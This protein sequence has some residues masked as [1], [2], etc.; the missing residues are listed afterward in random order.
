MRARPASWLLA[1]V[2]LL[3]AVLATG[4]L[5]ACGAVDNAQHVVDRSSL[6]NDLANRLSQAA[7]RT[8]TAVY[9]LPDGKTGTLAQAQKPTRASF[10]YPTGKLIVTPEWTADCQSGAS[11]TCAMSP[12]PSPASDIPEA[13]LT[14]ISERGLI[15]PTTVVGLLAAAALDR[16]ASIQQHDTTIAGEW[17]TCVDVSGVDNT[18]ASQFSTCITAAGVLASFTGNVNGRPIDIH[19]TGY[20][21]TT[22]PAPFTVPADAKLTGS[23]TPSA[24]A[25]P[26]SSPS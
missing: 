22:T 1:A 26:S 21:T 19:M 17:V 15:A 2:V 6:V 16:D 18:P 12:A 10:T 4:V 8:Y 24:V 9:Q 23:P 13:L 14:K 20:E 7:D 3:S 11:T 5:S 25:T